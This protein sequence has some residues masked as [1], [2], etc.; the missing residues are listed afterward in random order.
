LILRNS[1]NGNLGAGIDLGAD[2]LSANDPQDADSGP[3]GR[4]NAPV[5]TSA[6]S[7]ISALTTKVTGTFESTPKKKFRL[8]FFAS[9]ECT[10]DS[11]DG[12]RFID[13]DTVTT[14]SDGKSIF[15]ITFHDPGGH[16]G[17]MTA[18][19]S[20]PDGNTSEFS[21]CVPLATTP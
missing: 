2:G 18:T 17:F 8:E 19:A 14:G 13:L 3:N 9:P 16:F 5:L 6:E 11:S 21:N 7:A 15:E 4:Q 1:I 10:L 12:D 20:D